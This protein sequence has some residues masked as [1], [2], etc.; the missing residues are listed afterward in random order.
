ML[1]ETTMSDTE[2][3]ANFDNVMQRVA[4]GEAIIVT[5]GENQVAAIIPMKDFKVDR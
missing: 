2:V 5:R 4:D 1:T 3:A